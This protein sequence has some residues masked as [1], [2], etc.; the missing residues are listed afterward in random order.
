[1]RLAKGRLLEWPA[2]RPFFVWKLQIKAYPA[3]SFARAATQRFLGKNISKQARV[4]VK[5]EEEGAAFAN[6]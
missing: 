5:L 1:V 2:D 4:S 3:L 6:R